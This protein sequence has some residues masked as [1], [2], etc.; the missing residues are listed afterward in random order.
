MGQVEPA[1]LH[2]CVAL[3]Y[4]AAIAV[5]VWKS[6]RLKALGVFVLG[7]AGMLMLLSVVLLVALSPIHVIGWL[8]DQKSARSLESERVRLQDEIESLDEQ[9]AGPVP[10]DLPFKDQARRYDRKAQAEKRRERA[11][12]ALAK[13]ARLTPFPSWVDDLS[14]IIAYAAPLA[15]LAP[16]LWIRPRTPPLQG[17]P[18]PAAAALPPHATTWDDD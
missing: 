9:I 17:A 5:S 10:P 1:T 18:R 15:L 4:G 6:G 2:G 8:S 13:N 14:R 3:L 12:L 7:T 11:A 16:W